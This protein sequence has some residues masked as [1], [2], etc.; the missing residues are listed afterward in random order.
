MLLQEFGLIYKLQCSTENFITQHIKLVPKVLCMFY[1]KHSLCGIVKR[2]GCRDLF[3]PL[4]QAHFRKY[5]LCKG[6]NTCFFCNCSTVN[7]IP[8]AVVLFSA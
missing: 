4:L 5:I 3:D 2:H 7:A 8:A 6:A 1:V